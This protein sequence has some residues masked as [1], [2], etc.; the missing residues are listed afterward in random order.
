M[1]SRT[2]HIIQKISIW[3]TG[4]VRAT[5]FI[6]N[7]QVVHYFCAADLVVQ[8]YKHATQSGVSQIAYHFNKPMLVTDVG[9]L[10]ELIPD[11]KVG[12]VTPAQPQA[13]AAA[14]VDFYNH[15]REKEF[16]AN[17]PELKKAI[18]LGKYGSCYQTTGADALAESKT[19][20]AHN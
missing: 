2:K 10:A 7:S 3:K 12:Y 1:P 9:G 5:E 14:L 18:F 17:I 19:S 8:P 11:G 20:S 4:L 6:P 13:I 15:N 16:T